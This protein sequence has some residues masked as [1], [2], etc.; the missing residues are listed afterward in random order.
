VP[1]L[2]GAAPTPHDGSKP[3]YWETWNPTFEG[4]AIRV[5]ALKLIRTGT[6]DP[7]GPVALYDLDADPGE[8]TDLA[9][10][11]A[12]CAA[13]LEL[14]W[15]LNE[16]RTDPPGGGYAVTP[17]LPICPLFRDGFDSG[18]LRVWSSSFP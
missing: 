15:R 11:P 18:G 8:G 5:G 4:Q 9:A 7:Y 16:E 3:L 10:S 13:L 12:H 2:D 6:A 1:L 17:L 14:V